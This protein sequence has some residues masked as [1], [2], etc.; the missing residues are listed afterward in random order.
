MHFWEEKGKDKETGNKREEE[1]KWRQ[2]KDEGEIAKK[3]QVG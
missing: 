2:R 3:I 1:E